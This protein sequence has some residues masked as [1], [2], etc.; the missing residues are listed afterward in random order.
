MPNRS[1]TCAL[2]YRPTAFK[3]ADTLLESGAAHATG[4][5]VRNQL[6][7]RDCMGG[8]VMDYYRRVKGGDPPAC[9]TGRV[10][11]PSQNYPEQLSPTENYPWHN[12]KFKNGGSV[13][14]SARLHHPPKHVGG[15]A[16]RP[17][18]GDRAGSNGW[19]AAPARASLSH[20]ARRQSL[21]W[22]R[23]S[24]PLATPSASGCLLAF[25]FLTALVTGGVR[26]SRIFVGLPGT[27]T[28]GSL[29][30]KAVKEKCARPWRRIRRGQV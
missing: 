3:C 18:G 23:P 5:A 13:D 15:L 14:S 10:F 17:H 26:C 29:G 6:A 21:Y 30:L 25:R 7:I 1:R 22:K 12:I 20:P 16:G 19:N 28:D 24:A 2:V 9:Y 4:D 27:G 8:K 11:K